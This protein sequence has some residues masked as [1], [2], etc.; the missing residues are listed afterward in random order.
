MA[1]VPVTVYVELELGNI[2]IV[3]DVDP[4]D[5]KYV[6]PPDT[7]RFVDFPR[8]TVDEVTEII[9]FGLT[10][11]VE[12]AVEEHPIASVPVTVYVEVELGVTDILVD[13]DPFDHKYVEPPDAVSVTVPF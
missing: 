2:D 9:G 4:L 1:S 7:E 11:T 5:H 12:V 13:V 10:V 6:A 3:F 8:Q